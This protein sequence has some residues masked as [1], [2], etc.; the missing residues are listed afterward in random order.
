MYSELTK[1]VKKIKFPII[2]IV[3]FQLFPENHIF[4][5]DDRF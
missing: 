5:R 3:Q 1:L 4:S 2:Q